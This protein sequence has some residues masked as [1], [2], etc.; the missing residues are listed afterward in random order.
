MKKFMLPMLII[1]FLPSLLFGWYNSENERPYKDFW[2]NSYK[3]Y[4]NLYKDSDRD[5]VINY[6]D[7]NDRKKSIQNPYQKNYYRNS[8]KFNKLRKR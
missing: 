4:N 3:H 6:F 2:D 7:Y 8:F 1:I 5:G